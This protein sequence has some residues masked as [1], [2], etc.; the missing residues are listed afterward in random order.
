MSKQWFVRL[1]VVTIAFFAHIA[2]LDSMVKARQMLISPFLQNYGTSWIADSEGQHYQFHLSEQSWNIAREYCLTLAS[3]LVVIKNLQHMNWLISHYPPSN[4]IMSERTVQIGLVLIDKENSTEKEWKWVDNTSLNASYLEWEMLTVNTTEKVLSSTEHGRCALL[5]IDKRILKAV[6]CDQTP[7]FDYTNRFICQRSNEQHLEHE[8]KNNPLYEFFVQLINKLRKDEAVKLEPR[9]IQ[10]QGVKT[11]I[12]HVQRKTED[13]LSPINEKEENIT[14]ENK[15]DRLSKIQK[16]TTK[17]ILTTANPDVEGTD[18]IDYTIEQKRKDEDAKNKIANENKHENQ[19]KN[20]IAKG[21][22]V[23]RK[24]MQQEN[25]EKDEDVPLVDRTEIGF[26]CNVTIP[27]NSLSKNSQQS[28]K[29]CDENDKEQKDSRTWY[30]QFGD[31]FRNLNLFLKQEKSSDL[32]ALLDNNDNSKTL[33]ER[34]KESLHA[35]NNTGIDITEKKKILQNEIDDQQ[36]FDDSFP[37]EHDV[38]NILAREIVDNINNIFLHKKHTAIAFQ[39]EGGSAITGRIYDTMKPDGEKMYG[40]IK[41]AGQSEV[42]DNGIYG[43]FQKK[44]KSMLTRCLRNLFNLDSNATN[45]SSKIREDIM[46]KTNEEQINRNETS[47]HYDPINEQKPGPSLLLSANQMNNVTEEITDILH[48]SINNV[49]QMTGS[50]DE[51]ETALELPDCNTTLLKERKV[52]GNK[53]NIKIDVEKT[54]SNMK[55]NLESA[56]EEIKRLFSHS[57]KRL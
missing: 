3:D 19:A 43:Q 51:P 32:R 6:P 20:F 26:K 7:D 10:L 53:I 14:N 15:E 9:M 57:W 23:V 34:L 21:K 52:D 47:I 12:A 28:N 35:K 45:K 48:T 5:N 31:I 55:Q 29:I 25:T 24:E 33:I 38:G 4:S 1:T 17:R 56:S 37:E 2:G 54:I 11:K 13:F 18:E 22:L 46:S 8:K 30:E 27:S 40:K 44:L 50:N 36:Q 41:S 49:K 42:N 16:I 39:K